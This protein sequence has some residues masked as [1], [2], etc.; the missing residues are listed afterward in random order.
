MPKG[1]PEWLRNGM[2]VSCIKVQEVDESV[3]DRCDRIVVHT[4]VKAKQT[5]N[6][7]TGTQ[8]VPDTSPA[9][10]WKNAKTAPQNYPDLADLLCGRAAGRGDAGQ[11]TCFVSNIGLGLQFAALGA[12]ILRQAEESGIGEEL[13]GEWFTE[14]V[15][16]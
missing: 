6:V 16:P 9:G 4:K 5:G 3:F 15:H 12:L 10:W 14:S 7:L 11:I 8:H 13:P 1:E 2:H